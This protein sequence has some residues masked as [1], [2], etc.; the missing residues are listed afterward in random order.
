MPLR[1]DVLPQCSRFLDVLRILLDILCRNFQRVAEITHTAPRLVPRFYMTYEQQRPAITIVF[2]V[3]NQLCY[4]VSFHIS[5]S[6]HC[7]SC[8]DVQVTLHHIW[9]P[10]Y[11]VSTPPAQLHSLKF[12]LLHHNTYCLSNYH[13]DERSKQARGSKR[14]RRENSAR[15]ECQLRC[16]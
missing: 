11:L 16:G 5:R 2:S 12:N 3:P 8:P 7:R 9:L 4:L 1:Y 10:Y 14:W 15:G 6:Y 13:H